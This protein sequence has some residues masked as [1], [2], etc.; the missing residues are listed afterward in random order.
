MGEET[1]KKCMQM[2]KTITFRLELEK[3]I[4]SISSRFVG[5][6]DIDDAIIDT[7]RDIGELSGASRAYLFLFNEDGTTMDN[8]HEWCA[9]GVSPQIDNLKNCSMDI[10]PW[11]M[12]KLRNNVTI[13][14]TDVSKLSA[15][16]QA[17][18]EILEKQD[19]KSLLV[20]PLHIGRELNGF[21]GFDNV[22]ETGSWADN[23]LTLL[24]IS[25][26]ILGNA[27]E[28]KRAEE[29]LKRYQFM[30]ESAHD[31]IFFKDLESRY[32]I[33]NNKTLETFGLPKEK[34]IEKNDY[35][36]MSNKKEVKKNIEDDQ[37]VF[38]TSKPKETIKHM[39]GADGKE[40]WFQAIKVPQ[41]D[42]KGN[43]VG[44]VGIARDITKRKQAE[45][46]I[47]RTKEYLQ[48]I[49][50]S[51]SEVIISFDKNN[52]VT[53]W[54]KTAEHVTGY[55][56]RDVVGRPL[57]MLPVF[58]KS[59]ELSNAIKRIYSG[60]KGVIDELVLMTKRGTKRIIKPSY[61]II[62]GGNEE[63][64]G[65][66]FFGRDITHERESHRR[67]V[68]GNSYLISD[69]DN[70]SAVDLFIDLTR[71]GYK[72]LFIT[73]ASPEMIKSMVPSTD[74]QIELLN[75]DKRGGFDNIADLDEL[76]VKI[77]EFTKKHTDAVI[78]LNRID[79]LITN[80]S[81]E[82]FLKSLYQINTIVSENKSMLF[83]N[84]NPLIVDARQLA[85]VEDELQPLPSQKIEDIQIEDELFNILKFIFQ[86]NQHNTLVSFSQISQQFSIVRP[87]V[88]KRLRMLEE[89]GLIVIR[90]HGRTKSLH[91]SDKGKA[92]LHKRKTV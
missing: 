85:M 39:T 10:A 84:L 81:F 70:K 24:R 6:S 58:D 46:E 77:R 78:L 21:I 64:I 75:R 53:T 76:T 71:L 92:L 3:T 72:G 65:I 11:W 90:K 88:R 73:R 17:E 35:E 43:I 40:Y 22:I 18:K 74:I 5:V 62:E 9:E 55:K 25:S 47:I 12:K 26:E 23:D 8:T 13:Y 80:F 28:R 49:I 29:K 60:H 56:A 15:D 36:L 27:L 68:K 34:V 20:L 4:S 19:I 45:E 2:D 87:T 31:A 30:V 57:T 38:K 37:L 44:L 79:Y 51:A 50:N 67:L 41:Y 33:A 86:Q 48:N 16:A 66:L 32:I 54:N 63:S 7:L 52:R 83:L 14:V 1:T 42:H 59:H 89:N 82:Q 69:K 61:S 91:V